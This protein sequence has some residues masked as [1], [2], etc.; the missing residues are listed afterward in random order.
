VNRRP[1]FLKSC[2][3]FL[4]ASNYHLSTLPSI[5]PPPCDTFRI[6]TSSAWYFYSE[7]ELLSECQ[8]FFFCFFLVWWFFFYWVLLIINKKYEIKTVKDRRKLSR[9]IMVQSRRQAKAPW[10]HIRHQTCYIAISSSNCKRS[11]WNSCLGFKHETSRFSRMG[12]C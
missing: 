6:M 3:P 4:L 1:A 2:L 8:T 12:N 7:V 10:H 11:Q 5:F 9:Y